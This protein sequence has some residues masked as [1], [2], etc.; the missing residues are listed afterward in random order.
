MAAKVRNGV[1]RTAIVTG[2][3]SGIGARQ[4]ERLRTAGV[5]VV[6][7]DRSPEVETARADDGG[8]VGLSGDVTDGDYDDALVDTAQE[9]FG[10]VDMLFHCAGIMPGG[11]IA[12]VDAE[13]ILQVMSVNY[14]GTVRMVKAVLPGMRTRGCGTIVVLGSLTGYVPSRGFGAY[15]ASKAAVDTFVEILAYEEEPHGIQVLLAAPNAVKTPLLAQ[16]S[17]GPKRLQQLAAASSSPL[18]ISPDKVLDVIDEGL[19][20]GRKVVVPGGR[21]IYALRRLAPSLTWTLEAR[22]GG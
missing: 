12:D 10:T 5:Q 20:R 7:A 9:R 3:A 16:A 4:V 2:A 13:R 22:L 19:R 11:T 6:G 15:S 1:V 14:E 8:Y 21:G 18:M 17:G